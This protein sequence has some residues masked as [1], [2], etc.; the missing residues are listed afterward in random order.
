MLTS[1]PKE[2]I[3]IL[4][5][6]GIHPAA[7]DLFQKAGY[8][9]I[10]SLKQA[11]SEAQLIER[12]QDGVHLLGIRSKT[13]VSAQ[14]LN[15]APRLLS[16]GCFCIGTNQVDLDHA[17]EKGVAVFNSPYSNTRSVA[18]L[19]IAEMIMLMRRIPEKDRAAHDGL[20]FKAAKGCYEVRGKTLGIVGYGH[21]GSQVSVLAESLGLKV[22]YYD[23]VPK[24][25]LGNAT[26]VDS[27][28]LLLAM[29][30]VVSLHVPADESTY[31]LLNA[32][33]MAQMKKGAI[34]L[35]LS[36]GSV[37]NIDDLYQALKN[38]HIAGAGIDVF[39]REPK[40]NNE[41]FSTPLQRL[42][43]VI[44][45]PHI[46]GSTMEAQESIG[47]DVALK[48]INFIDKGITVGSHSVPE[49][50]L[51]AKQGTHRL[52]H[53]HRNV[54]GVLS[55]INRVI[56]DMNINIEGQYLSTNDKI[57]YVVLDITQSVAAA[58]LDKLR[59][60]EHTIRARIL[61]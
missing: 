45:T 33:T 30:D 61:Y 41:L 22:I 24:L 2:K 16:L 1:F 32:A 8:T 59:E 19:V 11:L 54:P 37:V 26:P 21:I 35:N 55:A 4:L 53:I 20:W 60:V 56:S 9:Q 28:E 12:L 47:R 50:S 18:E 52:L 5:L 3:K 6:E 39:P 40:A 58:A 51:P 27:L 49:I 43:N 34:L 23:I 38:K 13:Q 17:K 14:A 29:S 36:R 10:E 46:G 42:P 7:V 57:G 31:H 15:H 25:P 48:L 44:L